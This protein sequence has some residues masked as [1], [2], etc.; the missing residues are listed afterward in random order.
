V[1]LPVIL[2]LLLAAWGQVTLFGEWLRARESP[3]WG[4]TWLTLA[5]QALS[6]ALLPAYFALALWQPTR[7]LHD[8]LAGTYL[9]PR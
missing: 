2:L 1:W 5:A 9:V 7:A 4:M 6:V 3:P 8:R